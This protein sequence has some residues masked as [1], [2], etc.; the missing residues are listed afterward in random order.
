MSTSVYPPSTFLVRWRGKMG[1][2]DHRSQTVSGLERPLE[3]AY[4][5]REQ[6]RT[7]GPRGDQGLP[8]A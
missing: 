2:W 4:P 1:A 8:R 6:K 3:V 5:F 7:L